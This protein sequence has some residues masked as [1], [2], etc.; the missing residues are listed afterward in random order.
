MAAELF[1]SVSRL[2]FL[3]FVGSEGRLAP[4]EGL[5]VALLLLCPIATA[6]FMCKHTCREI[7]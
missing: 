2:A 3:V 7:D 5:G 1:H 4:V 6:V